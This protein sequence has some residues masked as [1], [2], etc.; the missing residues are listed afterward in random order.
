MQRRSLPQYRT[1]T[2]R[3]LL[4]S[5]STSHSTS[6][7]LLRVPSENLPGAPSDEGGAPL[8]ARA[9]DRGGEA[10]IAATR[11]EARREALRPCD[12]AEG[13]ADARADARD[14]GADGGGGAGGARAG[15]ARAEGWVRLDDEGGAE[16]GADGGG[17]RLAARG[18]TRGGASERSASDGSASEGSASASSDG[19]SSV[20]ASSDEALLRLE[21]RGVAALFLFAAAC[22][23]AREKQKKTQKENF[24]VRYG[25]NGL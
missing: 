9:A 15:E 17:L 5:Q 2:L 14:G 16:G 12:A 24:K 7:I 11:R 19:T 20:C 23:V 21:E 1:H 10:A 3:P 18:D 8:G 6:P 4:T 13:G 25:K 22:D